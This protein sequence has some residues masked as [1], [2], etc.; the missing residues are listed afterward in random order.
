MRETQW[1]L[2]PRRQ[3]AHCTATRQ[4]FVGG[5]QLKTYSC[6]CGLQAELFYQVR[7]CVCHRLRVFTV[8]TSGLLADIWNDSGDLL[9][10]VGVARLQTYD[11]CETEAACNAMRNCV[12]GSDSVSDAV[13][14]AHT[15]AEEERE[16]RSV[17]CEEQLRSDL[18]VVGICFRLREV[19]E[20]ILDCFK[21]ETLG[22]HLGRNCSS[23]YEELPA[24]K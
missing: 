6:K 4:S 10:L 2:L 11:R 21:A 13:T 15:T 8:V 12:R 16:Q 1:R 20:E 19:R 14:Q 22:R 17:A 23:Q 9:R 3:L 5:C 7:N 18:G 24:Y